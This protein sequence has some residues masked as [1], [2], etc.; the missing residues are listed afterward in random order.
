MKSFSSFILGLFALFIIYSLNSAF[1][2]TIF[3]PI[4]YIAV[5][6]FIIFNIYKDFILKK[7]NVVA[8]YA[9]G[10]CDTAGSIERLDSVRKYCFFSKAKQQVFVL[11]CYHALDKNDPKLF[12][13]FVEKNKSNRLLQKK[14]C[15]LTFEYITL[16][17][18]F[19]DNNYDM[20]QKAYARLKILTE[21]K[22]NIKFDE[23][24]EKML[25]I[26]NLIINKDYNQ[27]EKECNSF[28]TKSINKRNRMYFF[29]IEAILANKMNNNSGVK[30]FKEQI[31]KEDINIPFIQY[32]LNNL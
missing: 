15:V 27:A 21:K 10:K 3:Q 9:C 24:T 19:F 31:I 17:Y 8:A 22:S 5:G 23:P 26:C 11:D 30:F 20:F 32:Q 12:I 7:L 28:D 29:L 1:E 16:L 25:D 14:G 4:F 13:D 2:L 6:L 18:F